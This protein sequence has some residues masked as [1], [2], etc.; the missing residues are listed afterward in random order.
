MENY[1][2]IKERLPA[3]IEQG[4][5]AVIDVDDDYTRAAAERIERAGKNVVRVSVE[6]RVHDGY[7]AQGSRIFHAAGGKVHAVADLAGIGSLRGT[8]NAQNAACAIAAC[9]TL[10]IDLGTI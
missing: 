1:A 2:A 5:A 3:N 6:L 7:Y 10:G 8:H 4:G 9:V